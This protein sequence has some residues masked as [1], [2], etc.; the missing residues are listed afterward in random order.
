MDIKLKQTKRY[1][2]ENI[3]I[4][5]LYQKLGDQGTRYK[6][7]KEHL[8]AKP[9]LPS[10]SQRKITS[11]RKVTT[12]RVKKTHPNLAQQPKQIVNKNDPIETFNKCMR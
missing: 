1:S 8:P 9:K 4:Y 11:L 6:T 2:G 5:Q 7:T 3:I 12:K 10:K